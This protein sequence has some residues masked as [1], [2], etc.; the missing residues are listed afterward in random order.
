MNESREGILDFPCDV[1]RLQLPHVLISYL[2]DELGS[3]SE[4][5]EVTPDKVIC[6][7]HLHYA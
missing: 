3:G 2:A 7:S 1:E 5:L 4:I 6:S